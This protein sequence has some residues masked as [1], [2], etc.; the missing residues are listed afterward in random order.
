MTWASQRSRFAKRLSF[1]EFEARRCLSSVSFISHDIV[2][3]DRDHDKIFGPLLAAD[4]D[5]DGDADVLATCFDGCVGRSVWYENLDGN[6]VFGEPNV[7]S[8]LT[9]LRDVVDIDGDGDM[10]VIGTMRE[11]LAW[12][13]NLDGS[14]TFGEP[15]VIT[16]ACS[17]FYVADVDGD[18]DVDILRGPKSGR[19]GDHKIAWHENTNGLGSFGEQRI[20]NTTDPS[21]LIYPAD[22][23]GDDDMDI[24]SASIDGVA[25]YENT[26][27]QGSFGEQQVID[28]EVE[29]ALS[30]TVGDLDGDGDLDVVSSSAHETVWHENDDGLGG[31]GEPTFVTSRGLYDMHVADID[32]DGD[33]DIVSSGGFSNRWYENTDGKGT[34]SRTHETPGPSVY[35]SDVDGDGDIDILAA[36]HGLAWYENVSHQPGDANRDFQFDQNDIVEVLQSAKYLTGESATFEQGDWNADGVFD[37]LDIVA[38]LQTGNYLHSFGNTG[39]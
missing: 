26:N 11:G 3:F 13:K 14:G 19:D 10:D 28:T 23:D 36:Y 30:L 32:D 15:N 12:Y 27:G 4:L 17:T 5:G 6:G 25:W 2:A 24:L 29:S 37:Q 20:I 18:G 39:R 21:T 38:A 16:N 9:G 34:F 8:S 35:L 31:F 33:L 7:V 22:I 1:E